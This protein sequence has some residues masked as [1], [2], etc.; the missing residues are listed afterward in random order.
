MSGSEEELEHLSSEKAAFE[1]MLVKGL[2]HKDCAFVGHSES[3]GE[4][5][6]LASIPDVLHISALL[7]SFSTPCK[8]ETSLSPSVPPS[9]RI[10]LNITLPFVYG[11]TPSINHLNSSEA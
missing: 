7:M 1:D 9:Q 4:Y 10:T 8:H 5:S 2:V 11:P 6:A 3:L